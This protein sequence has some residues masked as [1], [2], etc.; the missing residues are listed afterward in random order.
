MILS[1][2]MVKRVSKSRHPFRTSTVCSEPVSDAAFEEDGSSG[3]VIEVF[4]DLDK[5]SADVVLLHHTYRILAD[6]RKG[7]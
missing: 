4:D 3:L 2:N 1:R 7:V 6:N 5:V